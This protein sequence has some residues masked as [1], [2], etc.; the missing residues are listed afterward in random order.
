MPSVSRQV[1][2]DSQGTE[3]ERPPAPGMGGPSGPASSE[4]SDKQ[5]EAGS[6]GSHEERWGPCR[7]QDPWWGGLPRHPALSSA[8][9]QLKG[10]PPAQPLHLS[11]LPGPA[12]RAWP[13]QPHFL[14]LPSSHPAARPGAL[15]TWPSAQLGLDSQASDHDLITQQ[16]GGHARTRRPAR[17]APSRPAWRMRG[18]EPGRAGRTCTGHPGR[19]TASTSGALGAASRPQQVLSAPAPRG[20]N[21]GTDSLALPS[22]A[23][24]PHWRCLPR[25]CAHPHVLGGSWRPPASPLSPREGRPPTL[26]FLE[27]PNQH[28]LASHPTPP[29]YTPPPAQ[30]GSASH[31]LHPRCIPQPGLQATP[32]QPR[33]LRA[34]TRG[35]PTQGARR[36]HSPGS[37]GRGSAFLTCIWGMRAAAP[38]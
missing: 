22:P 19:K 30:P 21:R 32:L 20:R 4:Q 28:F 31:P 15:A 7:P 9:A 13:A 18:P 24:P 26:A 11:W 35:R 37:V 12:A 38:R 1:C 17:G 23:S 33:P 34:G 8:G 5:R 3:D 36:K 29:A 2:Q 27:F 14:P 25:R 6:R 10:P 16:T